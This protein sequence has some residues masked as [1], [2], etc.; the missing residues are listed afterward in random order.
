MSKNLSLLLIAACSV[1]SLSSIKAEEAVDRDTVVINIAS[2]VRVDRD[3]EEEFLQEAKETGKMLT[4]RWAAVRGVS[5]I[6]T[7]V[8]RDECPCKKDNVRSEG[9][10]SEEVTASAEE[11]KC[12]CGKPAQKSCGKCC[13]KCSS[14]CSSCCCK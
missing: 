4:K 9:D 5:E 3:F 10:S 13:G 11:T 2:Q 6:E 1:I 7:T 12:A 14:S 8:D